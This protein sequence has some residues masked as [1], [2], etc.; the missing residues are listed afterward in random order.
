MFW[1]DEII[2]MFLWLWRVWWCFELISCLDIPMRDCGWFGLLNYISFQGFMFC[3]QTKLYR[4]FDKYSSVRI[5]WISCYHTGLNIHFSNGFWY[6]C[7]LCGFLRGVS[8]NRSPFKDTRRL[9][10]VQPLGQGVKGLRN[11]CVDLS[12]LHGDT[13]VSPHYLS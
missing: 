4:I 7:M 12:K 8:R 1:W 9:P 3:F 2:L 5:F 11:T 6:Q 13:M 10:H